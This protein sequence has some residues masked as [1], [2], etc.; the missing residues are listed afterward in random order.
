MSEIETFI[1][2]EKS[3]IIAPAGYGKTHTIISVLKT[4]QD[5]KK[6]LVLTHTHA[7]VASIREK[8]KKENIDPTT[9][10]LDTICSFALFITES[11]I[12]DKSRMP[13]P[14]DDNY[15]SF[16][17]QTATSLLNAKPIKDVLTC[18]YSHLIVDEY[19]DCTISQHQFIVMLS[20]M[21]KTH[22]LGDPLQGI[23]DF[24][25]PIVDMDSP[26]QMMGFIENKQTLNEPWRWNNSNVQLGMDLANIRR[27]LI[28][29]NSI[30][31]T[32]Y[33]GIQFFQCSGVNDIYNAS[34]TY[35]FF[36]QYIRN[37]SPESLL[38]IVPQKH[39]VQPFA[40]RFKKTFGI[41]ELE[42]F[43]DKWYYELSK[44]IDSTE[45]D[46][47][48]ILQLIHNILLELFPKVVVNEWI[49]DKHEV[50]KKKSTTD[51]ND[52]YDELCGLYMIEQKDKLLWTHRLIELFKKKYLRQCKLEKTNAILNAIRHAYSESIS[53][54]DG[55]K[56]DRDKARRVGRRVIGRYV[57]TTLL[58]KGLEFDTVFVINPN[59]F[60][61]KKHLYVALTR[62]VKNLI[63]ISSS[64]IVTIN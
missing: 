45:G 49:N 9:Y 61:N 6:M 1:N 10:T 27:E 18:T 58:T 41:R 31:I 29:P 33:Q 25:D 42:A 62:A 34:P 12:M 16:A 21:M 36:S 64:N 26:Q 15:F 54:Y 30:N 3:M 43:D 7:G 60:S 55:M 17:V 22:I 2:S 4:H 14:E 8:A 38:V 39:N 40:Q 47:N 59:D 57:G 28:S 63:V 52:F 44:Q 46:N 24:N 50:K 23:F 5:S 51:N 53:V 11:F 19:Q 37:N 48:N 13:S 56:K 35:N 32:N 20:S